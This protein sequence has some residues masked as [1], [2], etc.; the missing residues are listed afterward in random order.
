M[1]F[2]LSYGAI[3]VVGLLRSDLIAAYDEIS[4]ESVQI[5]V[6]T[7][8]AIISA[9]TAIIT[10]LAFRLTIST[11]KMPNTTIAGNSSNNK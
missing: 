9:V 8:A 3:K 7:Y 10:S 5:T 6:Y 11:H 4:I 1:G 2:M